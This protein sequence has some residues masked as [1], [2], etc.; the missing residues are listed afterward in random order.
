MSRKPRTDSQKKELLRKAQAELSAKYRMRQMFNYDYLQS[1]F[2]KTSLLI[3]IVSLLFISYLLFFNTL[4]TRASKEVIA[5]VEIAEL[6]INGYTGSKANKNLV[7]TTHNR[8]T[9]SVDFLK[10]KAGLF[11]AGD[12]IYILKNVLGKKSY[13]AASP[14]GKLFQ[15]VEFTRFDNFSMFTITLTIFS[16]FM[17]D[18]YDLLSRVFMYI[19]LCVDVG[20]VMLYFLI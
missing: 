18:G 6:N 15:L 1:N 9:Y 16:F 4:F 19:T 13:L 11:S 7:I 5:K 12:T 14:T 2:F 8:T 17:R 10:S 20:S 3:R